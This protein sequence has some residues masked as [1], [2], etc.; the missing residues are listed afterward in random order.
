[1]QAKP[2]RGLIR[3]LAMELGLILAL[4]GTSVHAME[5]PKGTVILEVAGR[6]SVSNHESGSV[7]F[8]RSML[9]ELG[10]IEVVTHT[11]WTEGSIRF[12]GILVRD[13]LRAV[14]ADGTS[15]RA[16][17]IND[18]AI[19]IP[20]VDFEDYPVILALRRDGEYMRIRDKGPLWMIYPWQDNPELRTE[21]YHS[22]SIWQLKHLT[23]Q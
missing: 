6:I 11:P 16:V 4:A 5:V 19:E 7:R 12:E 8:D 23:V 21:I 9:E 10:L 22:R 2:S 1:M 15:V 13:L 20:T 17:A 18:Y 14:G 3:S